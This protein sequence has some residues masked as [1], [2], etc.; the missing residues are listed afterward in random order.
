[1]WSFVEERNVFVLTSCLFLVQ[2]SPQAKL[3]PQPE[4]VCL[5][6]LDSFISLMNFS[7]SDISDSTIISGELVCTLL[8]IV[9]QKSKPSW[10]FLLFQVFLQRQ[11]ERKIPLQG[12][13]PQTLSVLLSIQE[14]LLP[15]SIDL[16]LKCW[17]FN[18]TCFDLTHCWF[19]LFTAAPGQTTGNRRN[20][21]F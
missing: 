4:Q 15:S 11:E 18:S 3:Q 12:Q 1:M 19:F 2:I 8:L 20:R 21:R 17:G 14:V 16:S 9:S 13:E 5:H 6:S 10:W 7:I